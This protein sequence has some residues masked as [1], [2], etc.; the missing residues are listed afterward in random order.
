MLSVWRR[1]FELDQGV[2]LGEN[3]AS[4]AKAAVVV[5]RMTG[6]DRRLRKQVILA[7]ECVSLEPR[8]VRNLAVGIAD[9]TGDLSLGNLERERVR[10]G[11]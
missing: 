8:Q 9:S 7:A 3:V 11:L 6:T 4:Q 10:C 5:T 2:L 1:I